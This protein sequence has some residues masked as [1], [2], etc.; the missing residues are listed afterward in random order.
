VSPVNVIPAHIPAEDLK[1]FGTLESYEEYIEHQARDSRELLEKYRAAKVHDPTLS[2][3]YKAAMK[4]IMVT[5][6]WGEA[7]TASQIAQIIT[8]TNKP[9]V[10]YFYTTHAIDETR[11]TQIEWRRI[12][13]LGLADALDVPKEQT[14]L[15]RFVNGLPTFLEIV[16]G[17]VC[18]LEAYSAHVLFNSIIDLARAHGDLATAATY[19]HVMHDEVRHIGTGLRLVNEGIETAPDPEEARFRILDLEEKLLP[20]TIRKLGRESIIAQSLYDAGLIGS[21]AKFEEDGWRQFK[22]FRSKITALPPMRFVGPLP[23]PAAVG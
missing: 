1:T 2:K 5:A 14:E 17:Q 6:C 23:E 15:F 3:E 9:S 4:P 7:Q 11:H 13:D 10:Q 18:T 16:Y 8:K 21:K 22:I 12:Q 20:I 19:E